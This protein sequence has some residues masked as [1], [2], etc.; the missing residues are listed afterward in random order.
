VRAAPV[1]ASTLLLY[2]V[3]FTIAFLQWTGRWRSWTRTAP[4]L[5]FGRS[6]LPYVILLVNV[7]LMLGGFALAG[8]LRSDLA[9]YA[10]A[11]LSFSV[12]GCALYILFRQP[13]WSLPP[14][15]RR[16]K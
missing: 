11:V 13:D 16:R 15:L 12:I 1:L 3:V 10:V 2:V 9:T 5:Y 14:W 4:T 7:P 8:Y 6:P